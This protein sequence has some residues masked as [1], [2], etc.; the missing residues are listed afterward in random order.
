[1]QVKQKLTRLALGAVLILALSAGLFAIFNHWIYTWGST[2]AEQLRVYPGDELLPSPILS[3]T[4]AITIHA[5]ADE[6]WP[7][8]AQMGEERGAFY[9]YSFIENMV[10]GRRSYTNT[11]EIVPE[12][13]NPQPG[14][15]IIAGM[16][17]WK[18]IH[19]GE[20]ILAEDT[21]DEMGWTWLWYLHPQGEDTRLI[22]RMRIQTPAG[23]EGSDTVKTVLNLG[24]FVME[25]NM[26]E[27][28]RDRVEGRYEPLWIE[29]GEIGLWLAA[30]V[31]G[32]WAAVGFVNRLRWIE[33]LGIGL[34][35]VLI[36]F[37]FTFGQPVV[38]LRVVVDGLLIYA[39]VRMGRR[40]DPARQD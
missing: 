31:C 6:V 24:G 3:W 33:P 29:F 16:M 20:W 18:E 15:P 10:S 38:W 34:S 13:Q 2:R 1:M 25:R 39:L 35:A 27:G 14:T 36:L 28:I 37:W 23:M 11:N 40:V 5:P 26:L 17:N 4:H 12:Y 30:L 8:I 22:I 32:I 21:I 9:S 19:T 7:W